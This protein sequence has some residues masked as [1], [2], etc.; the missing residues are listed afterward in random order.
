MK[1]ISKAL[2]VTQDLTLEYFPS[3]GE[4]VF[5]HISSIFWTD[6]TQN[7]KHSHLWIRR[8]TALLS[9]GRNK[10]LWGKS[11]SEETCFHCALKTVK[12]LREGVS[13]SKT[14]YI[15]SNQFAKQEHRPWLPFLLDHIRKNKNTLFWFSPYKALH[16]CQAVS[17]AK[18][19]PMT[20]FFTRYYSWKQK[21]SVSIPLQHSAR[22]LASSCCRKGSCCY[23]VCFQSVPVDTKILIFL[24]N[25]IVSHH[26]L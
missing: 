9:L 6:L 20:H 12:V 15:C 11:N 2:S 26:T 22:Y 8:G 1:N 18:D 24:H 3:S 4:N 10:I 7:I 19:A 23:F 21:Y 13:A 17:A 5:R 14:C 25:T 16:M